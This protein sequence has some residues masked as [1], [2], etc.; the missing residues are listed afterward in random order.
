[1]HPDLAQAAAAA[2]VIFGVAAEGAAPQSQG[3]A[4]F[5]ERL[6]DC[7]YNLDEATVKRLERVERA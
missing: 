5:K 7:L 2:L 4:S 6:F 3:P 1:M